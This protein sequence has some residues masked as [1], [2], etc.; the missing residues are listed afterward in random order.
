MKK[1]GMK[2]TT[3]RGILIFVCILLIGLAGI[4]FYFVQTWLSAYATTVGQTIVNA[5][6]G[7]S[8]IDSLKKLQTQVQGRQDVLTKAQSITASSQ[9][10]QIQAVTDLG[11]YAQ[12]AGITITNYGLGTTPV[13]GAATPAVSAGTQSIMLTITSPV[14]YTKLLAFMGL[15]QGNLPKM[16]VSSIALSRLAGSGSDSVQLTSLTVEV[17]TQ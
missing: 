1:T 13:A 15:V 16:Q 4:G 17:F 9:N 12:K 3:V 14:S 11:L 5:G 7:N 6:S 8:N 10:Y 2:A